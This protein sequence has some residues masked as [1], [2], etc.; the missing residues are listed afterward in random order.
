LP[1]SRSADPAILVGADDQAAKIAPEFIRAIA[2]HR[3]W[4]R[5]AASRRVPA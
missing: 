2:R 4:G 3:N 5:E 1:H